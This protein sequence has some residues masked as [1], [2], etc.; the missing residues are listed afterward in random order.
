MYTN[1]ILYLIISLGTIVSSCNNNST[2]VEKSCAFS[3]AIDST[4]VV[5]EKTEII[6]NFGDCK[7]IDFQNE[8]YIV[9]N[10]DSEL[11]IKNINDS[12]SSFKVTNPIVSS[13]WLD[14][15][16]DKGSILCVT[17]SFKDKSL[18]LYKIDMQ[19]L[20]VNLLS[21]V[22]QYDEQLLIDPTILKVEDKY[23][24]TYTQIKGNINN[25]DTTKQNGHYEVVL[26][27]SNDLINW[28]EV[29]SI[30]SENTNIE[31]GF[32]YAEGEQNSLFFLY[33]EEVFDKKNSAL[34]I[35]KSTD[36]GANWEEPI[37]LLSATADQEPAAI[38][39]CSEKNYLFY[40]SDLDNLG[41]SYWGSK[42]YV[43]SFSDSNFTLDQIDISLKLDYGIILY[44]VMLNNNK[45]HFLAQK[46]IKDETNVLVH[47]TFE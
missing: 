35:K 14:V 7:L 43:S 6:G 25:G 21:T 37:T 11:S 22:H 16:E 31:D 23:L 29:S 4:Y 44:D 27:E 36:G 1:S 20:N 32:L 46:M 34:K 33:E 45:M 15:I 47:Y 24:I 2:K 19:P 17:A 10:L 9:A 3:K 8:V 5:G 26:V 30:V 18:R 28:K 39:K 12:S 42:G 38:F 40:S 41:A 13:S